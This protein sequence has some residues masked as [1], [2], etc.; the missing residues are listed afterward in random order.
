MIKN[1]VSISISNHFSPVEIIEDF[2]RLCD[3][4]ARS[5][6]PL[7][8]EPVLIDHMDMVRD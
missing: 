5:Y 6:I 4:S 7:L 1:N 3:A 2:F 8:I